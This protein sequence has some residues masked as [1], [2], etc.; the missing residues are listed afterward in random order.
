MAEAAKMGLRYDDYS[1]TR[2][3]FY[4]F[5][6]DEYKIFKGLQANSDKDYD[7]LYKEMKTLCNKPLEI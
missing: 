3:S 4:T 6:D 5:K 1:W 2:K 7:I